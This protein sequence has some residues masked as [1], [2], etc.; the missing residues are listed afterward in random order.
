MR[1]LGILQKNQYF[2]LLRSSK[3][4]K[5][6]KKKKVVQSDLSDHNSFNDGITTSPTR[7]SAGG[8]PHLVGGNSTD[9][10]SIHS[11][12]P[13]VTHLQS[14]I[15]S[16]RASG[17]SQLHQALINQA[18]V[19]SHWSSRHGS[20][21]GDHQASVIRH[22]SMSRVPG[23]S[24]QAPVT[25]HQ[26]MRVEYQVPVNQAPVNQAPV[27]FTRHQSTSHGH[28]AP[29]TT[30][31]APVF[32]Q[33]MLGTK[34]QGANYRQRSSEQSL[35]NESQNTRN[36]QRILLPLEP[37]FSAISDRSI[38]I[39]P[40]TYTLESNRQTSLN[41]QSRRDSLSQDVRVKREEDTAHLQLLPL[42]HLSRK[43]KSQRGPD[44]HI[45]K[46]LPLCHLTRKV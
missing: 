27:S 34:Y 28:W 22:R 13:P 43:V 38:V 17:T 46:L 6:A 39:D 12:S 29:V 25:M 18:P 40:P 44:T 33:Q 24:H 31:Q 16:H 5:L 21:S 32:R 3:K 37:D 7:L 8:R 26:S 42:C 20:S 15:T 41:R 45:I 30:H 1:I 19:T 2:I 11:V 23:T 36:T 35:A 14:P 4:R 9:V 10:R